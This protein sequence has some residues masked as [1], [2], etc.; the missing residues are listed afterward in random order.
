MPDSSMPQSVPGQGPC[1]PGMRPS[2][3]Y[4]GMPSPDAGYACAPVGPAVPAGGYKPAAAGFGAGYPPTGSAGV[5]ALQSIPWAISEQLAGRPGEAS[6]AVG[7]YVDQ[8]ADWV[9]TLA[10]R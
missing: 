7:G 5:D 4:P 10:G 9:R 6:Q 3:P 1:P 8:Y 2:A